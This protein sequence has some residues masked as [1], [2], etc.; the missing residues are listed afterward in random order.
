[1]Q[2]LQLYKLKRV[3]QQRE[4]EFCS[5]LLHGQNKFVKD[6]IFCPKFKKLIFTFFTLEKSFYGTYKKF[7]DYKNGGTLMIFPAKTFEFQAV[8][9][10]RLQ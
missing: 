4:R 1:M 2:L 8:W 3:R 9:I 5:V 6:K 10:A 7:C